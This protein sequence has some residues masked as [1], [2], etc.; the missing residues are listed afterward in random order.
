MRSVCVHASSSHDLDEASYR[1]WSKMCAC[2]V[3]SACCAAKISS[4]A[5]A[6]ASSERK[7]SATASVSIGVPLTG[8][9]RCSA[10]DGRTDARTRV[11]TVPPSSC[12]LGASVPLVVS[13]EASSYQWR[14]CADS[15]R[16]LR[17]NMQCGAALLRAEEDDYNDNDIDHDGF[18][19]T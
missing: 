19:K 13:L 3:G 11:R 17:S 15:R 2:C 16:R 18:R 5:S 4:S 10:T 6:A 7:S 8:E 12:L 14:A 1:M 9:V